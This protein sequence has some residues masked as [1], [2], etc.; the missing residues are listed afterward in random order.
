MGRME[1]FTTRGVNPARRLDY[2]NRLCGESLARTSVDSPSRSFR[3]EMWRWS[4]GDLTMIRPRSEASRVARSGHS[5]PDGRAHVV[6]HLQHHGYSRHRQGRHEAELSPGSFILSAAEE[7]YA[8]D[9]GTEHEML[10]A[11]M[12]R[13]RLLERLPNLDDHMCRRIWGGAPSG[14]LFHDFLLSLWRQGDQSQSDPL[15][16]TGVSDVFY[17]MVALAVKAEQTHPAIADRQGTQ[18]IMGRLTELIEMRLA[19]PGLGTAMLAE[20]TGVSIRT[21]QNA[22]AAMSTTPSGYIQQR[23]LQRA[24]DILRADRDRSITSIAFDLGFNESA[25]FTRCFRQHFGTTPSQWRSSH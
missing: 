21:V 13:D 2:W 15:W 18:S 4:L 22:F 12:P 23:R 16:Q 17:D 19:D 25:Y 14:R 10:V 20:E 24:G 5:R 6:L 11:E 1:K 9:L 7:D 8:F 3:A